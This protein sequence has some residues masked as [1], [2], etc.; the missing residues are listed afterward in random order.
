MTRLFRSPLAVIALATVTGLLGC[1]ASHD[2][3]QSTDDVAVVQ[4]VKSF[5]GSKMDPRNSPPWFAQG[6]LPGPAELQKL[7]KYD[8]QTIGK[9]TIKGDTATIKMRVLVPNTDN[10]VGQVEW[11]LVKEGGN[12]KIK[13]APV[14]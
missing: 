12:W 11:T 7:A 6:A 3:V 10:E 5:N 1:A 8:C 14:P 13:S 4:T 2:A 9:P